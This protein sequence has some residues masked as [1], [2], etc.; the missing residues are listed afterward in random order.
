M[1]CNINSKGK[2]VRLVAGV[3][4]VAIAIVLLVLCLAGVV[5]GAG[6]V[7]AGIALALLGA[8]AMFEG[9]SGWCALRA[10]GVRTRL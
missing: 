10:M 3:C 6:W 8:F 4:V 5:L 7:F 2:A 9:W 1:Q